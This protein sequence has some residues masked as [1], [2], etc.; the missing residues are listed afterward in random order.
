MNELIFNNLKQN[1]QEVLFCDRTGNIVSVY[2]KGDVKVI[3]PFSSISIAKDRYRDF[4][5]QLENIKVGVL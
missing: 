1:K 2:C 3:F 5:R 4:R